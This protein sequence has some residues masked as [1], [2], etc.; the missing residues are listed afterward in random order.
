[1][2]DDI[3]QCPVC[4][5]MHRHLGTPPKSVM[6]QIARDIAEGTFPKKSE[7]TLAEDREVSV[8]NGDRK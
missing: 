8:T 6:E 2:S 5:R 7:Q 4:G 3:C 1:M